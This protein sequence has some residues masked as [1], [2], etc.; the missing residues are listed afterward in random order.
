MNDIPPL[1][2]PFR[3]TIVEEGLFRGAYPSLKNFRFLRRL[4]LR[5]LVTLSENPASR[6]LTE[7]CENESIS[8]LRYDVPKCEENVVIRPEMAAQILAVLINVEN[9]PLFLHCRDGGHNTGLIIMLL[10]RLQNWSQSTIYDEFTRYTKGADIYRDESAYVESFKEEIHLPKIIPP[11]LW[12]GQ[13]L[14]SHPVMKLTGTQTLEPDSSEA[15]VLWT[16]STVKGTSSGIVHPGGVP[17]ALAEPAMKVY[18]SPFEQWAQLHEKFLEFVERSKQD[19]KKSSR[20]F[21]ESLTVR[22]LLSPGR[23]GL[24]IAKKQ[25]SIEGLSLEALEPSY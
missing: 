14:Q 8:L 9:L 20:K 16:P 19:S 6:D 18:T 24:A 3:F 5:T 15:E 7:F 25:P 4:R 21:T 22:A 23:S 12:Q 17:I 11:W 13:P 1:I 2:P 10:R